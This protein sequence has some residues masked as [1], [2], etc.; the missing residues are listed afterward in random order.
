MA[1]VKAKLA[2]S[3][4]SSPINVAT[5]DDAN[6]VEDG[7]GFLQNKSNDPRIHDHVHHEQLEPD[8]LYLDITSSFNQMCDASHLDDVKKVST[9]LRVSCNSGTAFSDKK[10]WYK[11]M[12][13]MWLGCNGTANLLPLPRLESE[14]YRIT[15]DT[16]TSWVIQVSDG[17][18]CTLHTEIVLNCGVGVCKVFPYLDMS[19]PAHSNA[20]VML[21]KVR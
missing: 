3:K 17:P 6:A 16:L 10:G 7:F 20:V 11:G 8:H 15:Y 9:I 18:L 1:K 13:H 2:S 14:G 12:F 19:Y 5:E 21:Q 4:G